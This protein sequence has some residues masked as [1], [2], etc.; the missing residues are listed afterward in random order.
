MQPR[1]E[2]VRPVLRPPGRSAAKRAGSARWPVE[3]SPSPKR[4]VHQRAQQVQRHV[5]RVGLV[6]NSPTNPGDGA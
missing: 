3:P 5:P 6:V 4:E 1:L 2:R